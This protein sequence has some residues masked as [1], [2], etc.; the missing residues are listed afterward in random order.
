MQGGMEEPQ[1]AATA[2]EA[3]TSVPEPVDF[4]EALLS[5]EK[6]PL[7]LQDDVPAG[8]SQVTPCL[9]NRNAARFDSSVPCQISFN[10]LPICSCSAY[11]GLQDTAALHEHTTL[12]AV[13]VS[14]CG[15]L[16]VLS[17]LLAAQA[18]AEPRPGAHSAEGQQKGEPSS[19]SWTSLHYAAGNC[20]LAPMPLIPSQVGLSTPCNPAQPSLMLLIDFCRHSSGVTNASSVGH[21]N[22][23]RQECPLHASPQRYAASLADSLQ[24][25]SDLPH[26]RCVRDE[27]VSKC[28]LSL[29]CLAS[30]RLSPSSWVVAGSQLAR[31]HPQAERRSCRL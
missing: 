17:A 12:S 16:P 19:S 15:L 23:C 11:H 14:C 30:A 29:A 22:A 9:S 24:G 27:R 3:P 5:S 20:R 18:T 10:L 13:D 8:S 28:C 4:S 21:G 7:D 2:A 31:R 25:P 1:T 26:H 6:L